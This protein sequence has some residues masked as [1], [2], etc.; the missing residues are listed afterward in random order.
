MS[1]HAA[2][3]VARGSEFKTCVQWK[4]KKGEKT[5]IWSEGY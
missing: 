3:F 1:G 4:A 2:S 5:K